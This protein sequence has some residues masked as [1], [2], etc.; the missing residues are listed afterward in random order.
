MPASA[1]QTNEEVEAVVAR[2]GG[3]MSHITP[4]EPWQLRKYLGINDGTKADELLELQVCIDV[5]S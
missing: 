5:C 3:D 2:S 4:A 1:G